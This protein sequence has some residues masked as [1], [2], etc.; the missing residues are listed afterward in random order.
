MLSD[1]VVSDIGSKL[2]LR[3]PTVTDFQS[4]RRPL[5]KCF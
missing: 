4:D 3:N 2:S 1:T 5:V